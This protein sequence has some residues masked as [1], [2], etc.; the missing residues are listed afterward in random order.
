MQVQLYLTILLNFARK[1]FFVK[2]DIETLFKFFFL[3]FA[4]VLVEVQFLDYKFDLKGS[5][6]TRENTDHS[7]LIGN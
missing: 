6:Y 1:L 2:N 5:T 7:Y 4:C 3:N